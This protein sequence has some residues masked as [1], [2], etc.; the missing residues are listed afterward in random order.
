[1]DEGKLIWITGLGGS[2]KTTIAEKVFDALRKESLHTIH[3]DGDAMRSILG[4]E[5]V[6]D[7]ASRKRTAGI[8]SKLA[9]M[10]VGQG[11]NVV[12]STISLFHEIH[13]FNGQNNTKYFEILVNADTEK[14]KERKPELYSKNEIVGVHHEP[15]FPKNPNLVL[16]NN[17]P[18][19]LEKNII[20]ILDLVNDKT[21]SK[22]WDYTAQAKFYHKRP[23]YS[24][25]AIQKMC[26]FIGVQKSPD[27]MAADIGAGTGNLTMMLADKI[28]KIIAVEPNE[29]MRKFGIGN[30]LKMPNVQWIVGAGEKTSLPDNSI[31]LVTFGSSF[32]TTDRQLAL[33][34]SAR[35]LKHG[36]YFV[37]MWNNRDLTIPTQKKSEEIIR[38][39]FPDYSHG[40]RRQ[41][42][43][44]V[45]IESGLFNDVHYLEAPQNVM[46][47]LENYCEAWKSVKN[48]YWDLSKNIGQE[49][50]N[51]ILKDM[52]DE[53]GKN[54]PLELTYYT[55][56]WIAQKQ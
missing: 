23:N 26:D 39:Y 44:D 2:G 25:E 5:K 24:P 18:G 51:K 8:Y 32:N 12:V 4:E 38:R 20:K 34:E 46:M 56:I 43:A 35:I 36:G 15:E 3:L 14:R 22:K 40:V 29:E 7:L 37:C 31:D 16:T 33:K 55:K 17:E 50:L 45:I 6:H 48:E 1:M 11:I 54:D 27:Y 28:G 30:T 52:K 53:L 49:A 42:Q 21:T 41:Q 13:E 47:P 19:D 10:L 9:N